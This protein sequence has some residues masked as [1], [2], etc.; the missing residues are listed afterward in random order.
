MGDAGT[1]T[2][3]PGPEREV[4]SVPGERAPG[5]VVLSVGWGYFQ[6]GK[7]T[8][9]RYAKDLAPTFVAALEGARRL[10]NAA[11]L[12]HGAQTPEITC[13]CGQWEIRFGPGD[14]QVELVELTVPTDGTVPRGVPDRRLGPW[15]RGVA[16]DREGDHAAALQAFAKEAD[17]AASAGVPQRAAVAYRSAATAARQAGRSDE[18]NRLIRLAG[19]AY[20]EIA[21]APETAAQGVFMAYREAARCLLDAGN[22]PLA[23]A[24]LAK[25]LATGQALGLL[26][27]T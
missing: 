11:F 22:L 3:G 15:L 7:A 1:A 16:A 19:K 5:R 8:T 13:R 18:A 27:S 20:L 25:A 23:H 10:L 6:D 17:D 9:D 2:G 14:T 24:T 26:E 21:E 12:E 4:N